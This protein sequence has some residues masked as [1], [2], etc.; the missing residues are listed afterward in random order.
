M[1]S[2]LILGI[3]KLVLTSCRH[4]SAKGLYNSW[5]CSSP[6]KNQKTVGSIMLHLVV[7]SNKKDSLPQRKHLAANLEVQ[8]TTAPD[9]SSS[10]QPCQ[11][12][13]FQAFRQKLGLSETDY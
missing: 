9:A 5:M 7:I 1:H 8:T 3:K 4:K 6:K 12:M 2:I 11:A 13:L 10:S